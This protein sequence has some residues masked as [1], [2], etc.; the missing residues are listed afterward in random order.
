MTSCD[1]FVPYFSEYLEGTIPVQLKLEFD[2]HLQECEHCRGVLHRMEQLQMRMRQLEP[3]RTSNAFHIVLRSRIRRELEAPTVWERIQGY[4]Q[5]NRVPAY[6]AAVALLML[7]SFGSMRL[8]FHS[9]SSTSQAPSLTGTELLPGGLTGAVVV[10]Q[11]GKQVEE[12]LHFIL[13]EVPASVLLGKGQSIDS[14]TMRS[15]VQEAE[16][17]QQDSLFSPYEGNF[18]NLR[19]AA[20][21]TF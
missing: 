3:V 4:F 5:V 1:K 16:R 2:A 11:R 13:D 15:A 9:E 21:V 17:L 19:R 8:L 6:A 7:I 18:P 10:Q 20:T 14:Q 12:R